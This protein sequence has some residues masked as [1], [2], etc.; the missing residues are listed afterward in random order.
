MLGVVFV[1]GTAALLWV[2]IEAAVTRDVLNDLPDW[3]IGLFFVGGTVIVVLTGFV[4][5][6]RLLPAWR[7]ERSAQVLGGVAAMVMTMFAVLL[8]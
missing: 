5:V 2:V 8:A 1:V 7:A 3:A 4:L 6:N